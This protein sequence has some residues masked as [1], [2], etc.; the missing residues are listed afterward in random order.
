MVTY[1]QYRGNY[2]TAKK[3]RCNPIGWCAQAAGELDGP[4]GCG[5][6]ISFSSSP[7]TGLYTVSMI[8]RLLICSATTTDACA[9]AHTSSVDLPET[10]EPFSQQGSYDQISSCCSFENFRAFMEADMQTIKE[11]GTHSTCPGCPGTC[12]QSQ[13][14]KSS[15]TK[16]LN[17]I[18]GV[19]QVNTSHREPRAQARPP[20]RAHTHQ[21]CRHVIE[22]TI[23]FGR[24]HSDWSVSAR[25]VTALVVWPWQQRSGGP[26]LVLDPQQLREEK[27]KSE[28]NKNTSPGNIMTGYFEA[29]EF[30]M[31]AWH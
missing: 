7:N 23:R 20:S 6:M 5:D 15:M 22:H 4:Q 24:T 30:W 26:C 11:T 25:E 2:C 10:M 16:T 28:M 13:T 12:P 19:T 29:S 14:W 8:G 21:E 18:D 27:A 3:G 31:W 17:N 1:C 9:R